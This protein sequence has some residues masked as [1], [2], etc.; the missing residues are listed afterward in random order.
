MTRRGDLPSGRVSVAGRSALLAALA[1]VALVGCSTGDPVT[2]PSTIA[3]VAPTT[4]SA[5]TGPASTPETTSTSV[6]PI[7]STSAPVASS[8]T[9]VRATDC[10]GPLT[11][12]DTQRYRDDV[13]DV[14]AELFSLD[15]YRR[16]GATGCP[17][18]VWVH[19]GGWRSGD[20]AGKAIDTKVDFAGQ[21]GAALISVNYRLVTTDGDVRW[22]VMGEDVAAAVAW[23]IEHAG[24][25]GIDPDRVA[26][27]G[28]SAGAHLVSI[29]G[30]DP[31][32]LASAGA[33]R[34][35][36]R[37]LVSLDSAA[38]DITPTD[39]RT[40]PLLAAAFGDDPATLA[41]ASPMV[42]AREHPTGI[43]DVLV[44]TR[45]S[46]ARVAESDEFA[47]AVRAG[48]GQG[49]VVDAGSYT[50]EQVNTQLGVPS[51][52]VVTPP[53]RDFLRSCFE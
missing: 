5:S 47:A 44:V 31:E 9:D 2:A 29:V 22:P 14:A 6:G 12:P 50:H 15:V 16:P 19:G 46:P 45:G 53:T 7:A 48:G 1:G 27:M 37:C 52:R 36:V 21:M 26:L 18:I 23:V 17:V 38:Y 25:L 8:S 35:D 4:R 39:A 34:E 10:V 32:L 11:G 20:K 49:L 30:T 42:Q 40:T 28:H 43:P 41:G 24:E 51:E 13:G 33:S 3:V